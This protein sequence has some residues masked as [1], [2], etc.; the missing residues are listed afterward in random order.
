MLGV[1]GHHRKILWGCLCPNLW[2][3][4]GRRAPVAI[5]LELAGKMAKLLIGQF[6]GSSEAS[7]TPFSFRL[8]TQLHTKKRSKSYVI[9]LSQHQIFRLHCE[10]EPSD[11]MNSNDTVKQRRRREE[12]IADLQ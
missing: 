11:A 10:S 5:Q 9:R 1:P 6:P 12:V 2:C 3:K 7:A 4:L 8:P